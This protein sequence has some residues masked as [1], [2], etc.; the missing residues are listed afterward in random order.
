MVGDLA[1]VGALLAGQVRLL[2]PEVIVDLVL[3]HKLASVGS[4]EA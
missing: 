3:R 2:R 4:E 1:L